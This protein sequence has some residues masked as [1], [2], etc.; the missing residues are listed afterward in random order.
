MLGEQAKILAP[1]ELADPRQM[2]YLKQICEIV[3][4]LQ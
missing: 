1:R 3:E 2:R 4:T